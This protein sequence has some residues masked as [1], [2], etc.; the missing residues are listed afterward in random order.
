MKG[1]PQRSGSE[2]QNAKDKTSAQI[3]AIGLNQTRGLFV[4]SIF[5][6]VQFR[7][8]FPGNNRSYSRFPGNNHSNSG[9]ALK[10]KVGLLRNTLTEYICTKPRV[11]SR[12]TK[13]GTQCGLWLVV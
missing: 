9:R 11:G 10:L 6:T 13:P 4:V 3:H 8:K 5:K 2:L 7:K 12:T 1:T